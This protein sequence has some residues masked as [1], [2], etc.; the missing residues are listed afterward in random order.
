MGKSILTCCTTGYSILKNAD[1]VWQMTAFLAFCSSASGSWRW[2]FTDMTQVMNEN[3][4]TNA[5]SYVSPESSS[6]T[7]HHGK[8]SQT[9]DSTM[10]RHVYPYSYFRDFMR[11]Q[12]PLL[13][14]TSSGPCHA[15]TCACANDGNPHSLQ[16]GFTPLTPTSPLARSPRHDVAKPQLQMR[17]FKIP[18]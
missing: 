2:I 13:S 10:V 15:T 9:I 3:H 8:K 11:P 5:N 12:S 6:L 7:P 18:T 16:V 1:L 14:P 17:N 4:P